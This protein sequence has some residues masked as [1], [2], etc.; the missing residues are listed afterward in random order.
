MDHCIMVPYAKC[1]DLKPTC[2]IGR[3]N[4]LVRIIELVSHITYV[5]C[6]ILYK[7]GGIYVIKSTLNDRFFE[8]LFMKNSQSFCQKS[9]DRKSPKKSFF[10]I[11]F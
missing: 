9:A 1:F 7:Y 4:P 8:K 10:C 6:V 2:I 5:V 3:Y 11:L